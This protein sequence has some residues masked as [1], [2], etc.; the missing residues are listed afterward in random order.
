MIPLRLEQI[1]EIVGG[2]L[3][4]PADG[5]RVA[6]RV[7][8]DSREAGPGAL[9]VA[10]PGEHAD[11]HDFVADAAARGAT[12][13]LVAAGRPVPDAPGPIL[14]DDPLDALQGLGSWIRDTVD[15]LV[16]AIT[17]SQ[18][19]TTTKDLTR[20]ALGAGLETVAAPGS[21][22]NDLGVPLTC[23]RLERT[24]QALVA[25]VGTRG[26]GHIARLAPLLRPD[27]AV[28]TAVGASHLELLGSLD[29]VAQAKGELVE[30]LAPEGLAVLAGDD[31]R[32]AGLAERTVAASVT[33]G[34][35]AARD[36]RARE[37]TLDRRA[38]ASFEALAPDGRRVPVRLALPGAHNVVN[39]LCALAVADAAGVD[40]EAAAAALATARGSR[41]RL[42]AHDLPE[43]GVVLND[44]YNAN[45]ASTA[46][47]L[48]ALAA[49]G[50]PGTR[51]A[52]LGEM[53]ELGATTEEAHR[54]VGARVAAL[55]LDAL[56]VVGAAAEP[57]AT[58]ARAAGFGGALAQVADGDAA[59]AVARDHVDARSAVLV[60]ASR[61]VGLESLAAG[62]ARDLGGADA[63]AGDEPGAE[64]SP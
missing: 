14:V 16:V 37:V 44:A 46:A 62:L 28:V 10:L 6:D 51:V 55:G 31:P 49:V 35:D 1:A 57:I 17:G 32:V 19:K 29:A 9:F 34:H 2:D 24:S 47:A 12:G 11:G 15:P 36:W 53:A 21:Y 8:I 45:P 42:E 5:D 41:W 38:R 25:E 56:I 20:A 33:V 54:E 64:G 59:R 39:A 52:I 23:A 50:V 63:A 3:A 7:V 61:A 48:D 4:G 26:I 60:K 13:A 27:I 18:G 43:G 58:G 22:N 40:L 30:A